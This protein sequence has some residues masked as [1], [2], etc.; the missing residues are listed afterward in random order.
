MGAGGGGV[1]PCAI[2]LQEDAALR[3]CCSGV[4]APSV[5]IPWEWCL[6]LT[7]RASLLQQD[8]PLS[9]TAPSLYRDSGVHPL[10]LKV[11]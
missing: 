6:S 4:G 10:V 2:K 3:G 1:V 9:I 7:P 11:G 8:V 5:S